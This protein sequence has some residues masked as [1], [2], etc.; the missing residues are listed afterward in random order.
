[1]TVLVDEFAKEELAKIE[2]EQEHGRI[3]ALQQRSPARLPASQSDRRVR[4]RNE[5][6]ELRLVE[7]ELA[8]QQLPEDSVRNPSTRHRKFSSSLQPTSEASQLSADE[9]AAF[10]E[11]MLRI[12]QPQPQPRSKQIVPP[13]GS[14]DLWQPSPP[15]GPYPGS[16]G[17]VPLGEVRNIRG[18]G[19]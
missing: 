11:E 14:S 8:R 3:R 2:R 12:D 7:E 4:P 10:E 17:R 15:P 1:M 18:R 13:S 6:A 5:S 19:R 16:R 9:Q